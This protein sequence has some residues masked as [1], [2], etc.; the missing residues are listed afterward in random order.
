MGNPSQKQ[1]TK[2]THLPNLS[3]LT[4][5]I[6]FQPSRSH[7]CGAYVKTM[8]TVPRR[9][10]PDRVGRAMLARD[11]YSQGGGSETPSS[12][13]VHVCT[14]SVP[15][16]DANFPSSI[17]AGITDAILLPG[18]TFVEPTPP[19]TANTVLTFVLEGVAEHLTPPPPARSHL[20][21]GSSLME[22]LAARD[23]ASFGG[24]RWHN[25]SPVEVSH[26][27]RFWIAGCGPARKT[28]TQAH[29]SPPLGDAYTPRWLACPSGGPDHLRS[30]P[31]IALCTQHCTTANG[32][33][34]L[35]AQGTMPGSN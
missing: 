28:K 6:P 1:V 33:G 13:G 17:L 30:P 25:P 35:M 10:F 4:L 16:Q 20:T 26:L 7:A 21:P 5:P 2:L 11:P 3:T 14:T 19:P 24:D 12:G 34:D 31:G 8:L 27:L 29:H 15:C 9:S 23:S 32:G 22:P 18:E